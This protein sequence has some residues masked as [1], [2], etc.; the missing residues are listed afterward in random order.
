M[1]DWESIRAEYIATDISYK[2]LAAKY[3]VSYRQITQR[4]RDEDW[5]GG[6][7][8]RRK[9][10]ANKAIDIA[11][12]ESSER[13]ARSMLNLMSAADKL[14]KRLIDDVDMLDGAR[15]VSDIAKALK[16]AADTLAQVYGIQTPAQIHRQRMDEEKL[17][18]ER[19]R[20]ELEKKRQDTVGNAD[21]VRIMIVKPEEV[22]DDA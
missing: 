8:K 18:I 6:R 15:D 19:E 22:E 11:A 5:A 9:K 10:I 16:Y 20:F 3:G 17:K 7:E 1:Y 4:G 13:Q 14:S 21:P 12:K 2:D